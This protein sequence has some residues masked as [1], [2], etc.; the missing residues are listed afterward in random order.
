MGCEKLKKN[1]G[2]SVIW[3]LQLVS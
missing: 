1:Q 2:A 3:S